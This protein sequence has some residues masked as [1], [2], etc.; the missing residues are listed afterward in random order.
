MY[1][2]NTTLFDGRDMYI[3]YY[4]ENS[5]MFRNFT[6]T[7][8]RLRNE[9][10]NLLSSY[11]RLMRVLYSGAVRGEVGTRSGMCYVGWVVWVHGFCYCMLF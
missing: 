1:L 5:Y 10:K 8:F 9:K 6:L 11:T 3:V 2:S 7:I 4:I